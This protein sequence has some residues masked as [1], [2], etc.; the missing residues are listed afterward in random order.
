LMAAR[1][2]SRSPSAGARAVWGKHVVD[3][4]SA[5]YEAY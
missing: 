4:M 5:T 2:C 1:H 3:G